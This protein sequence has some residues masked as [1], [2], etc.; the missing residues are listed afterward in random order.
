MRIETLSR[1]LL[2]RF[3]CNFHV[4]SLSQSSIVSSYPVPIRC[5]FEVVCLLLELVFC[6][7]KSLASTSDSLA[8][9]LC[10]LERIPQMEDISLFPKPFFP[11]CSFVSISHTI[12]RCFCA[13]LCGWIFSPSLSSPDV[14]FVVRSFYLSLKPFSMFSSPL[15]DAYSHFQFLIFPGKKIIII[16]EQ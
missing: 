10:S 9:V 3:V 5:V 11:W 2:T 8:Y 4:V 14:L 1:S 12:F 6:A 16:S 7:K 13:R 15:Q